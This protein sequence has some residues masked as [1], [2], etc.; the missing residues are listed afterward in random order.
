M[1]VGH[2]SIPQ[3]AKN[4]VEGGYGALVLERKVRKTYYSMPTRCEVKNLISGIKFL[5]PITI[6]FTLR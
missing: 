4:T 1:E 2:S 6:I 5:S 3:T